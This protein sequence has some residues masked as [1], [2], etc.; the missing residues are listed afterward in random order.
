MRCVILEAVIESSSGR[1]TLAADLVA[2]DASLMKRCKILILLSVTLV[3]LASSGFAA[4]S[5]LCFGADGHVMLES[6]AA[7]CCAKVE[8]G[9][10]ASAG[11]AELG[12]VSRAP[13]CGDCVDIV[14]PSSTHRTSTLPAAPA[15]QLLAPL[16]PLLDLP[17]APLAAA[18]LG[19][20][21][22]GSRETPQKRALASVVLRV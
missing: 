4:G 3:H 2:R 15:R 13:S 11:N 20:P 7:A 21:A 18:P 19:V 22:F 8:D 6:S 5:V 10:V 9:D 14:L 16:L 12:S 17:L 1:G